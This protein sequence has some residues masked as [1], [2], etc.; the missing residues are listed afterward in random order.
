MTSPACASDSGSTYQKHSPDA[1]LAMGVRAAPA[2]GI[3]AC[4]G[5]RTFVQT[6]PETDNSR[7]FSMAEIAASCA[8]TPIRA[9]RKVVSAV[10]GRSGDR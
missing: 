4:K 9:E 1:A 8:V 5:L 2:T 3:P 6:T 10:Q 7:K